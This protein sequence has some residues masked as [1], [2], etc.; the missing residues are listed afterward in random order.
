M[1]LYV[2]LSTLSESGRRFTFD[3]GGTLAMGQTRGA[4][5]GEAGCGASAGAFAPM[6]A[7]AAVGH[8]G[9][10]GLFDL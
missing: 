2:M 6:E 10:S 3:L 1:S 8:R 4:A 9:L 5:A 7:A